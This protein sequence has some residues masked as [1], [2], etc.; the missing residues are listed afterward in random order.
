M[1]NSTL[2]V[3]AAQCSEAGA[4][5]ENED[6]MG[7]RVPDGALLALKGVS[8]AIADGVSSAHA[9]REASETCVQSFLADYYST[10]ESWTVKTSAQRVLSALNHWL[11]SK[12]RA[13]RE[14]EEGFLTTLSILVLKGNAAHIFH[15]GDTRIARV[16]DGQLETLTTDHSVQMGKDQTY[17]GRAMGM[18]V[19]LHVD[20]REVPV[21][22]GDVFVLTTDGVHDYVTS[23]DLL[24]RVLQRVEARAP[25]REGAGSDGVAIPKVGADWDTVCREILQAATAAGSPD[26]LTCQI[27]EVESVPR[28]GEDPLDRELLSLPFPPP[29]TAGMK[30]D[31][32]RIE[33]E[34]YASPRSQVYLVTQESTGRT[35][36]MKTPAVR[37]EDDRSYIERFVMEPWIGRRVHNPHVVDVVEPEQPPSW[38]YYLQEFIPGIT[39]AEWIR[40]NSEPDI[41]EV[42]RLADQIAKGLYALHRRETYHRDLKPENIL[43]GEDGIVRIV[44]FGSCYVSGLQELEGVL[45]EEIPLG[46]ERYSA[47]EVVRGEVSRTRGD[48][49]SFACII[50]EMLTGQLPY[51]Q[52][53]QKGRASWMKRARYRPSTQYNPMIPDWMD[54]ALHRA[55]ALDAKDRY[56][57]ISEFLYDLRHP[58]T[59][60]PVQTRRAISDRERADRWRNAAVGLVLLY[61]LTLA[62]LGS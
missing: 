20:Y 51:G 50:Y 49:F 48:L 22:A 6:C 43:L 27:I 55:V 17:L 3:D 41:R 11:Y 57:E 38:L 40:E 59:S 39:L 1:I 62:W 7:L 37:F 34:L 19:N 4:K 2:R 26:N 52:E 61:I 32:L 23:E 42:L 58:N 21:R 29:L 47:P 35:L 28:T 5:S 8:A 31:G 14:A 45:S 60:L 25:A 44:D 56:P 30:L 12:G 16:R 10:P 54:A 53:T 33:R 9:G 24:K 46:T 36:V 15:V 13:F 18:D